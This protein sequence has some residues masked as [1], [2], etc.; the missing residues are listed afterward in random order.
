MTCITV[1]LNAKALTHK[2]DKSSSMESKFFK[3]SPALQGPAQMS[4]NN[5]QVLKIVLIEM[6]HILF[7]EH[8]Q[9]LLNI[10]S[11]F[12]PC[13]DGNSEYPANHALADSKV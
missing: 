3:T 11:V 12:L 6:H 2:S 4:R 13:I 9:L 7:S 10:C 8:H 1:L 5:R